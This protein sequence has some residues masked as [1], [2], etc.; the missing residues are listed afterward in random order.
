MA[1]QFTYTLW[2][3][4]AVNLWSRSLSGGPPH[5]ITNSSDE[6]YAYDWSADGKQL[7]LTRHAQ[8]RDVVLISNF[9]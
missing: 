4:V 9:H 2:K 1:S 8:S 7:A 3:G 5:Q 6:L